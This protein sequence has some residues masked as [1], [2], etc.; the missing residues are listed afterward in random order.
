M[1][2]G[3]ETS[4]GGG[5]GSQVRIAPVGGGGQA[6]WRMGCQHA[7]VAVAVQPWRRDQ[8]GEMVDEFQRGEVQRSAPVALGLRQT[9]DDLLLGSSLPA[10]GRPASDL[11]AGMTAR[12]HSPARAG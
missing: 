11:A 12:A 2:A 7:M 5:G 9:I 3:G 10:V 1:A 8:S 6:E 4:G